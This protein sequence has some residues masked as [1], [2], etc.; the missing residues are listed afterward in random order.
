MPFSFSEF[1]WRL[2]L[3]MIAVSAVVSYVGDVV[4][5]KIGKKRVSLFGLRPRYTSTVITIM[6]GVAIAVATLG[7]AAGTSDAVRNALYGINWLG[8]E[9]ARLTLESRQISDQLAESEMNRDILEIELL[10]NQRQLEKLTKDLET[11]ADDLTATRQRLALAELQTKDAENERSALM[12]Q[13]RALDA[14]KKS[15]EQAVA[16]L[17][18]ES[19]RLRAGLA[20]M[21]EGRILAFQ[22]EL[23]SQVTV[24]GGSTS[25][26]VE[27][28]L[29]RLARQAEEKLSLKL[30]QEE[31]SG[32]PAGVTID[33]ASRKAAIAELRDAKG[34][35]V[36][37]LTAPSNIVQGQVV[38]GEVRIFDSKLIFPKDSVIYRVSAQGGMEPE[39]ASDLLYTFLKRIN[40]QAV[41]EGVLSDPISGAV[42]N[43]DS[44]EFY[45]VT[46]K[47]TEAEGDIVITFLA[48][49]DIYTE[50][51]VNVKI[52][53]GN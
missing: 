29:V 35:K 21:K 12:V 25:Q 5:M 30:E 36:L 51:P 20:E 9:L 49:T 32:P 2:I 18:S 53:L 44:L 41:E 50:G 1:N 27:Y 11:A 26:D 8:R 40:K 17:R 28:A 22:G 31:H 39:D 47:M 10:Q 45:N 33:S 19:E 52:E 34:R 3:L 24:E 46:D 4:G 48:A 14:E 16:A 42:G 23:L 6:T 43:L 7:V 37:R 38:S 13:L 15:M